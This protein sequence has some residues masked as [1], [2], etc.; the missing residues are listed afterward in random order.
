MF[1]NF[2]G[3]KRAEK[4]NNSVKDVQSMSTRNVV[5]EIADL[6]YEK[7]HNKASVQALKVF[8]GQRLERSY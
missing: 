7:E 3:K 5:V 1:S 4:N 2:N 6:S 8:T